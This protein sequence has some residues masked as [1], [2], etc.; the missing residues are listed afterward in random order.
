MP[1]DTPTPWQRKADPWRRT[2]RRRLRAT[3][4]PRS[5]RETAR[6]IAAASLRPRPD[7]STFQ[8]HRGADRCGQ[9][10]SRRRLLRALARFPSPRARHWNGKRESDVNDPGAR[11]RALQ[12]EPIGDGNKTESAWVHRRALK[13]K[14]FRPRARAGGFLLVVHSTRWFRQIYNPFMHRTTHGRTDHARVS[15]AI[16]CTRAWCSAVS[17]YCPSPKIIADQ[18]RRN[19]IHRVRLRPGRRPS[20]VTFAPLPA[21]SI[22]T[23]HDALR[24]HLSGHCADIW[25]SL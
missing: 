1:P 8:A 2:R 22:I 18:G 20:I 5:H 25:T 6:Q 24:V 14:G 17:S 7:R 19:R 3:S 9:T 16:A 11:A 21:A 13:I 10:A 12:S 23:P 4:V 15:V